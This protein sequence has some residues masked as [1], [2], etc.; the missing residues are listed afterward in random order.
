MGKGTAMD[1]LKQISSRKKHCVI[2]S[3]YAGHHLKL[4]REQQSKK[5]FPDH[6][7]SLWGQ[8]VVGEHRH[9]LHDGRS[10]S[11]IALVDCPS[12]F[13]A[14]PGQR[15]Q[16]E[17]DPQAYVGLVPKRKLRKHFGES[18]QCLWCC[19]ASSEQGTALRV[20]FD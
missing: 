12:N 11:L 20:T 6:G 5:A 16:L 10:L 15:G 13:R 2:V 19:L 3:D 17:S 4:R 7:D 14:A 9:L 18:L 1:L 8:A